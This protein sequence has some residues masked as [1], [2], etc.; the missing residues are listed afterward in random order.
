MITMSEIRITE[1]YSDNFGEKHARV[2]SMSSPAA[3]MDFVIKKGNHCSVSLCD[4]T[5]EGMKDLTLS[6]IEKY[7]PITLVNQVHLATE[8]RA[9]YK[10]G[11]RI[12]TSAHPKR[13]TLTLKESLEEL[14]NHPSIP[15]GLNG[16]YP[17]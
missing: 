2:I 1:A 5:I 12:G 17:W 3:T 4:G 7:N 16:V 6:F 8:L 11:L 15:M 10:A 14:N 9:M 13:K